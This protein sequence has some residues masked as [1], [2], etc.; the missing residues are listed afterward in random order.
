LK[1]VF[2]REPGMPKIKLMIN[3]YGQ[4]VGQNARRYSGAIGVHVRRKISIAC[5]DWRLVDPKIKDETWDDIKVF[6]ACDFFSLNFA[7]LFICYL[8]SVH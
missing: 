7:P 1:S 5:D 4:P 8:F 3:E 6:L 2:E